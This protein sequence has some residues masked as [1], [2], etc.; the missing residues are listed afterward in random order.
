MLAGR[1]AVISCSHAPPETSSTTLTQTELPFGGAAMNSVKTPPVAM[2]KLAPISASVVAPVPSFVTSCQRV[3]VPHRKPI[4]MQLL[5]AA[6][7]GVAASAAVE[8]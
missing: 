5:A 1:S 8:S 7:V 3:C 6:S 4:L 2:P